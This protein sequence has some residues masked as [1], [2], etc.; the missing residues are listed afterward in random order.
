M[1]SYCLTTQFLVSLLENFSISL[2]LLFCFPFHFR[3]YAFY[4]I[5]TIF[6]TCT[7]KGVEISP[8]PGCKTLRFGPWK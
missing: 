2:N 4:V 8:R 7:N 6:L 3:G 1:S 5:S